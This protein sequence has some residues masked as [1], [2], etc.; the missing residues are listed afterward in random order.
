[1]DIIIVPPLGPLEET[2]KIV[3]VETVRRN[4]TSRLSNRYFRHIWLHKADDEW[5]E[6][7]KLVSSTWPGIDIK[8]PEIVR[9]GESFLQMFYREGRGEREL[10]W[11]GFGF[12]V[13]L[14]MLTH[15]MRGTQNSILVL[16]E[17]D[18]YLHPDLQRK[19][20]KLVRDR[21]GQSFL[22]T[23]SVEI[24][25]EAEPGDVVS[26]QVGARKGKRVL[27]DEDYQALFSYIG[28]FENIDFSRLGRARRIIFLEGKDKKILRKFA[29][30]FGASSFA[31]DSDTLILQS[32]GFS[33]WRRVKEVAWTFKEV[34]KLDVT[35]ISIFDRDYRSKEQ[36]DTFLTRMRASS[37]SCFVL[38]RK[39]IENYALTLDNLVRVIQARQEERLAPERCLSKRQIIKLIGAVS[40]QFRYDTGSQIVAERNRH[41]QEI[42]SPIDQSTIMKETSLEVEQRWKNVELRLAMLPGKEFIS[43]LSS[44]LQKRKG[45]SVTPNML[46]DGLRKEEIGADWV[47]FSS[48][49]ISFVNDSE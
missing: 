13:W 46:I 22:A 33:Q 49:L 14:Q 21:F 19:L 1:L 29:Q 15:I 36:V 34:L 47:R 10:Y 39:E 37:I 8:E 23:H 38:E 3:Q 25:N 16:D 12:Q 31:N 5:R 27:T 11:S 35:I 17:P 45:F 32:G 26:I 40:S 43:Q 30:K 2:E 48:R 42:R 7:Q 18:I 6:F 28:S 41:F 4:E 9:A 24:I 44:R 20:L